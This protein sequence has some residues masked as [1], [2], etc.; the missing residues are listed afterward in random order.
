MKEL[1]EEMEDTYRTV[2][3]AQARAAIKNEASNVDFTQYFKER[4]L[5]ERNLKAA[6]YNQLLKFH[7]QV[8]DFHLG[9]VEIDDKVQVH[10]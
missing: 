7:V 1:H 6:V 5:V 10:P 4:T 3:D 2:V 9:R 8:V